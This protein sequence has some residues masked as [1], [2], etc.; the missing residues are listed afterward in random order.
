MSEQKCLVLNWNVRGLN[1]K[2]RRKVVKDLAQDTKC[3]IA[4]LQETKL[5]E[6]TA[7]DISETLGIKFSKNFAYLPAQGTRG[8]A[9]VAVDEDYYRISHS[10]FSEYTITVRVESTQCVSAWWI[11]VVYGPQGDREKVQFL[12]ERRTIKLLVGDKW[13]L[14]GD[15]NLVL[16]ASDKSN[17]NLNRRLMGEFRST[18]N[19]LELKELNLRGRKYTWSNDTTQTRIDR[20]FC[21]T[22]WDLMLPASLLQALSSLVSDHSPLLLVGATASNTYR[23]FRF[24][25]F[26]PKILG[27]QEVVQH[28]WTQPVNVFNPFLRLH[29]KLTR[30]AKA[31]RLWARKAV[32]NNKLLL[33]AARQL[34]AILDVE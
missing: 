14:L 28:A 2:A 9:L 13:L 32:G 16:Q 26:W 18:I 19:F 31:L 10:E 23:G 4:T 5:E 25:A 1:N 21:S 29:I 33:C 8:G 17:D 3:T 15:F 12:S 24:E 27:Y 22:E 30:T 34:I 7:Q 11:T 6:V 20:A